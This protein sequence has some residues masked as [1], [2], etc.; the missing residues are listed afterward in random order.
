MPASRAAVSTVRKK[1]IGFGKRIASNVV[2]AGRQHTS[3][4]ELRTHNAFEIRAAPRTE[5]VHH[6]ASRRGARDLPRH[7][8][9][10]LERICANVRTDGC[11]QVL[12]ARAAP[13]NRVERSID[14]ASHSASPTRVNG[15][16]RTGPH[17]TN[18]K[19]QAIGSSDADRRLG[20]VRDERIGF[21]AAHREHVF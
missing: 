5:P 13:E 1:T 14:Y 10:H 19:R 12:R 18:E 17:V 3:G 8:F 7:I 20:R 4:P 9:V 2:D 21:F 16:N 15:S 11:D 6:V